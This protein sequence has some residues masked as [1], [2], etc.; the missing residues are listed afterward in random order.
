VRYR[1]SAQSPV[2]LVLIHG[3]GGSIRNWHGVIPH[4]EKY[5]MVA[6]EL[7]FHEACG[8]TS[9]IDANVD[10]VIAAV[11]DA[12]DELVDGP[13]VIAGHSMGVF[14]ALQTA[15]GQRNDVRAIIS[16]SGGLFTLNRVLARGYFHELRKDLQIKLGLAGA[17]ILTVVP[18][19]LPLRY[20]LNHSAVLRRSLWPY[21]RRKVVGCTGLGEYFVGQG[22]FGAFR[23]LRIARAVDLSA[24]FRETSVRLVAI[25]G[26]GDPLIP[27]VDV[28]E[29]QKACP[30][31]AVIVLPEVGHWPHVEDPVA[32]A[33]IIGTTVASVAASG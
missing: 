2:I 29:L 4:L 17:L 19:V 14:F 32:V 16:I 27:G 15:A 21:L 8:L 9:A 30:S 33:G 5:E 24:L 10:E 28:E 18:M 12:V 7:P 20:G 11:A 25:A 26:E 3:M 6:I 1:S 31:G 22:G 23:L 13:C